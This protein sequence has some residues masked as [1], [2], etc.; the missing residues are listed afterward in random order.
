M[1]NYSSL[2]IITIYLSNGLQ[3]LNSYMKS[4]IYYKLITMCIGKQ[5]ITNVYWSKF[6]W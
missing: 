3:L 4:Q 5:S 6:I 1:N 2:A